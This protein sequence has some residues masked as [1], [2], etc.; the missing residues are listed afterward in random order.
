MGHM[1][2]DSKP[3]P[4]PLT[5]RQEARR[6]RIL[7][8]STRLACGGGFDAVQMREV[9]ESSG[10]ALGTLYRY[11]P[12]KIH[13]LVSVL[14]RDLETTSQRLVKSPP[15]G[16]TPAER[17]LLVLGRTTRALQ[18]EPDLTEALT[19]AYMFADASASAEIR[20]VGVQVTRLLLTGLREPGDPRGFEG[21]TPDELAVIRMLGDV[22]LASLVQWVTGR[23][24]TTDVK[25]SI[26]TAV[27]LLLR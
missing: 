1:S 12:S 6:R 2:T 25:S 21:P 20:Q 22:W 13:L 5:E 9:A 4:L 10:V 15:A 11:F 18:R 14:A 19:R 26:E 24:S 3:S 8:A 16:D 7:E 27:R 17:V 23:T